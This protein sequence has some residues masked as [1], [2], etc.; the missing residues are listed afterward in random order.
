MRKNQDTLQ[1]SN[2][3]SAEGSVVG[4]GIVKMSSECQLAVGPGGEEGL[5]QEFY[6]SRTWRGPLKR[7]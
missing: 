7:H 3:W 2:S 5:C 4:C 1:T 6:R